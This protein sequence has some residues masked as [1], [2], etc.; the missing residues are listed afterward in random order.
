MVRCVCT[1]CKRSQSLTRPRHF[2]VR[3]HSM[4]SRID[5]N[6]LLNSNL[7]QR[8]IVYIH[9][10][11]SLSKSYNRKSA[12][13]AADHNVNNKYVIIICIAQ[14]TLDG[15]HSMDQFYALLPDMPHFIVPPQIDLICHASN[16]ILS[17]KIWVVR[18]FVYS[19]CERRS[20]TPFAGMFE[21]T[22][23]KNGWKWMN[24][25]YI[26]SFE[27][28]ASGDTEFVERSHFF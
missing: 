13:A 11:N 3:L 17:S 24:I 26:I 7:M 14:W 15:G 4:S 8:N 12:V 22:M 9:R 10:D 23:T 28:Q 19:L 6:Y 27:I 1:R 5:H 16:V 18:G 25:D 20:T 2:M 21:T